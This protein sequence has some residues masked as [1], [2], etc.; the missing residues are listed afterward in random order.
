MAKNIRTY[1][2]DNRTYTW[3]IPAHDLDMHDIHG[4]CDECCD[5]DEC[6]DCGNPINDGELHLICVD[7]GE[8]I[9]LNCDPAAASADWVDNY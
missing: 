1:G 6:A 8:V 7:N 5:G 9:H 2:A 4:G 3:T